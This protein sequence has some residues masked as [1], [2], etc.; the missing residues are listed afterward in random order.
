M[1]RR[2]DDAW[3]AT[4]MAAWRIALLILQRAMSL[5][6]LA[7][8]MSAPGQCNRDPDARQAR[9]ARV[10]MTV[11]AVGRGSSNGCLSRSLVMYRYLCGATASPRLIVGVRKYD[12]EVFGHAWVEVAG[13]PVGDNEASI[14]GFTPLMEFGADGRMQSAGAN[15]RS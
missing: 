10:A 13:R 15:D 2:P 11:Y 4:R 14:A 9:V 3:L 5:P 6:R 8:L 12:D 7:R 1:A